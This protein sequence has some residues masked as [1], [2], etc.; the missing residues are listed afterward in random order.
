MNGRF[1]ALRNRALAAGAAALALALAGALFDA[2]QFFRSYLVAYLFWIGFPLG[3]LALL[4]LHHLVGG[5]WGFVIQRLLE[6]A[7]RTFP[8][9]ALLFLPLVFGLGRLYVWA[10]PE[11][12]AADPVLRQKSAYLNPGFFLARAAVYFALWIL[13]GHLL[14]KWSREQDRTGDA[15]LTG[16]MQ[17][18]S[19]PGLVVYG[20]TVTFAAIDWA[21]SL[22]PRW[23]STIY[24]MMFMVGYGLA[25]LALAVVGARLLAEREPLAR[26]AVPDRFHDLGNLLLALVMLWAYLGFS[27]FLLVWSENLREEI[28]WYVSRTAG[29]W[30]AVA[31]LLIV[32]QFALPFFLLLSRSAKRRAR[33]LALIALVVLA[34]RW[35][36]ILWLVAPAFHPGRFYLHWL[37]LAALVGVGGAW[38]GVF[39]F[40]LGESSLLPL[41]DPRF[42]GLGGEAEGT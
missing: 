14:A 29:G 12:V 8:L 34:M 13:F 42:A 19:A 9:M 35:V 38:L 16:R 6:A 10:A 5:R 4:M 11:A 41:G 36:D 32:F 21:M 3:S 30:Q 22:E 24:G 40:F 7:A 20:L 33:V 39:L 25:A 37:D 27:Q 23:Y 18:L 17:N 2:P 31:A 15:A 26:A 28:P 1:D